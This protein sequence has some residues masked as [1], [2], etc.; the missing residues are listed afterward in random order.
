MFRDPVTGEQ[1]NGIAEV[2]YSHAAMMEMILENPSISQQQLAIHFGVTPGWVSQVV[3]SDAFQAKLHEKREEL[4]G[5]LAATIREKFEAVAAASLDKILEKLSS[6]LPVTDKFLIESAQLA[7]DA[8]GYGAKAGNT[9][10]TNLAVVV[11]L[12]SKAAS[13][14]AWS[15]RYPGGVSAA[16]E[17][18][19]VTPKGE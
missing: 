2:R 17:I 19:D 3:R 18:V 15:A 6:P 4:F 11:Q 13:E 14:A 8:L 1:K 9:T 16:A 12:P 10:Q 5:P 7:K